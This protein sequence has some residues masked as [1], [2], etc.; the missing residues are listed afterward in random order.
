MYHMRIYD[1]VHIADEDEVIWKRAC[2]ASQK[3]I[4]LHKFPLPWILPP[5]QVVNNHV[6]YLL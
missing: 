2:G 6:L 5:W 4:V 3:S 1:L